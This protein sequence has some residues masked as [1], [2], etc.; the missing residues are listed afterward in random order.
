MEKLGVS[1]MAC[2]ALVFCAAMAI[3]SSAQ[4]FTTLVNFDGTNG[5]NPL[6]SGSLIQG[7]DGNL[8]GTT[9]GGGAYGDGT[10]F[11]ITPAGTLTT[12]HSFCA[13]TNCPDGLNPEGGL[14]QAANG[15][16]YGTTLSGGAYSDGT[17]FLI[18]P[19]G[20][21]TTLYSFCALT[22]CTDGNG[23]GGALL[24]AANG[25]FYGTTLC[26]HSRT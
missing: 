21:L 8:Y 23:P 2:I 7:I 6:G 14:V 15:S 24:Q 11:L 9:R 17:V 25:N 16:F 13:Q 26:A 5:A 1:K 3:A 4:S 18:T 22:N 10:V 12:L 20:A 19:A